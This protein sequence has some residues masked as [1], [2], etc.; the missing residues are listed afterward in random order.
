[1]EG[2]RE[3]GREGETND[4]TSVAMGIQYRILTVVGAPC[5]FWQGKIPEN[6]Y[7]FILAHE[8]V[9]AASLVQ[10]L[11]FWFQI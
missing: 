10:G 4:I 2:E 9:C 8:L 7:M 6:D 11:G 3:G 5:F 1:M